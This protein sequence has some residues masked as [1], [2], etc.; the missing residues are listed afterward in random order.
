MPA[1]CR[2]ERDAMNFK[3]RGVEGTQQVSVN[4]FA[5]EVKV[6]A[7]RILKAL[8][9]NL[10][11]SFFDYV[12]DVAKVC[13]DELICDPFEDSLRKESAKT[14]RFCMEACSKH[15]EQ[16]KALFLRTNQKM[17]EDMNTR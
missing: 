16:A 15:P 13:L 10:G 17:M 8:A 1:E 12:E 5:L 6:N 11:T 4:T 14:L 7:V 2:G 3:V 9:R